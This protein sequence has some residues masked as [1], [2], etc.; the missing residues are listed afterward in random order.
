MRSNGPLQKV[1]KRP[2]LLEEG[3][4]TDRPIVTAL[5]CLSLDDYKAG[6]IKG[7]V[8]A[9]ALSLFG[10]WSALNSFGQAAPLN[11]TP[12]IVAAT[13]KFLATLDEAQRGK[14]VF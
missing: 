10:T 12:E 9:S 6:M 3:R 13:K 2:P 4:E 1:K 8:L 5:D 11:P 14:A 7:I